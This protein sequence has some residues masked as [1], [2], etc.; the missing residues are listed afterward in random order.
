MERSAAGEADRRSYT[1]EAYGAEL[2][3]LS[4]DVLEL[5]VAR[6]PSTR[7]QALSL[8]QEHYA[9]CRDIVEQGCGSL[10]ALSRV[11]TGGHSWYFWWD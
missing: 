5:Q 4:S 3:S 6:P 2:V 11:L 9:Y 1:H 10:A 8:A 7:A